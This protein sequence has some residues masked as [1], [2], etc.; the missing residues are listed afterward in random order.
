MTYE[1]FVVSRIKWLSSMEEDLLHASVGLAGEAIELNY[2]L[3]PENEVEELGDLCFYLQH[4]WATIE[5]WGVESSGAYH[6][7]AGESLETSVY[8]RIIQTSGDILDMAKKVWVYRKPVRTLPLAGALMHLDYLVNRFCSEEG[9]ERPRVEAL[10]QAKLEKRYPSG[11]S[12]AAA[13][14]RADKVES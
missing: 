9:L 14:A 12:D 5:K 7:P 10:N 4:A 11:Y 6:T 13:Q 8:D 2:S 3:D 1:A